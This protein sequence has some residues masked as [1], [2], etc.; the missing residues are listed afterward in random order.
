MGRPARFLRAL[1][2]A[3]HHLAGLLQTLYNVSLPYTRKG[4]TS[5]PIGSQFT[6]PFRRA[7]KGRGFPMRGGSFEGARFRKGAGFERAQFTR[8]FLAQRRLGRHERK[9]LRPLVLASLYVFVYGH[10][11]SSR[12]SHYSVE[13]VSLTG[14]AWAVRSS[15]HQGLILNSSCLLGSG[16]TFAGG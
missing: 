15:N 7:S 11:N 9:L 12:N 8:S 14:L 3:V 13:L 16:M 6:R 10:A 4:V 1:D 2:K 5:L